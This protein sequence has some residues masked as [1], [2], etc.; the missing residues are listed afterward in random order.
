MINFKNS[1]LTVAVRYGVVGAVLSILAIA[2]M[3]Y[4]IKH[5][6][7][8]LVVN[9][10]L[11]V[12]FPLYLL[13]IFA[14]LKEFKDYYGGGFLH[15]W[16]AMVIGVGIYMMASLGAA[17]FIFIMAKIESTEFLSSYLEQTLAYFTINKEEYITQLG[18]E[19]FKQALS[20]LKNVSALSLTSQY[21]LQSTLIGLFLTIIMSIIMR[22]KISSN[23]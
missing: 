5:P 17:L 22:K 10:L 11:D 12:R 15:F 20:G 16:Q 1:L 18:E 6:L 14:G 13:L 9:P 3:Y 19:R 23:Q 2:V 8:V 4:F 21:L 7:A